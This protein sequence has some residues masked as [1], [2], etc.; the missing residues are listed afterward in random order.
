MHDYEET[1]LSVSCYHRSTN[2]FDENQENR[3]AS[4][5]GKK[6]PQRRAPPLRE[7]GGE[8]GENPQTDPSGGPRI[9]FEEGL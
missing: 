4:R 1:H 5:W 9:V 8:Q 7:T 6:R 3:M 2:E